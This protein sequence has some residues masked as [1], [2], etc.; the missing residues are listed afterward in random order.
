MVD[1][2][3]DCVGAALQQR[4]SPSSPWQPL[5]FFSRKLEPAQIRYLAFDHELFACCAGIQHFRYMLE[6]GP[7]TIYTDHNPL[8]YA[9]GKVADGWTAMQCRKLSYVVEFTT[10][11]RH[12]PGVDNVVADTLSRPPSHTAG[13][14]SCSHTA[15]PDSCSHT[16]GPDSCSHTAGPDS[17]SHTAGAVSAVSSSAELLEYASIAKNHLRGLSI[18]QEGCILFFLAAGG[19]VHVTCMANS[20]SA[21]CPE[22]AN[23]HLFRRWTG[24]ESSGLSTSCL[25]RGDM[26]HVG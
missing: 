1:A 11:I 16:A 17:C 14:D 2:S 3:S 5:A 9:L 19:G 12:V 26:P 22:V 4:S 6:G 10:D 15:R 18:D 13:P 24:S 20:C 23:G 21:M 25:I 8:T 7:F